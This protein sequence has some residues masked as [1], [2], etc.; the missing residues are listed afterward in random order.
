MWV[1]VC[2]YG[3]VVK[4]GYMLMVWGGV[5]FSS[6][7]H[8][9]PDTPTHTLLSHTHTTHTHTHTPPHPHRHPMS[10]SPH[11]HSFP[12]PQTTYH[13]QGSCL[14]WMQSL[15]SWNHHWLL[16]LMGM[17]VGGWVGVLG[18][19]GCVCGGG[20]GGCVY[21]HVGVCGCIH[22]WVYVGVY[23][24]GCIHMGIRTKRP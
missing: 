5:L 14:G 15:C 17:W 16:A 20:G 6:P 7:T 22:M 8:P 4:G 10:S 13:S 2:L 23:T 12:L 9:I 3:C 19:C 21:T 24:C 18:M 11:P 1:N